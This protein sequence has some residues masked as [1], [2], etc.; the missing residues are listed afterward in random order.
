MN[1]LTP[2]Q[3]EKYRQDGYQSPNFAVSPAEALSLRRKLEAHEQLHGPLRDV[4]PHLLTTWLDSLVRTR[5]LLDVVEDLIGPDILCWGSSFFIKEAHSP[6]F[7][8]W[9]QDANYI[10]LQ[11]N[12]MVTAW[13][14]LTPSNETNGAMRV[15]PRTHRQAFT[16]RETHGAD[17]LLSRGQEI[18]VEVDESQAVMMRLQAGEFSLH[19]TL[20]VHGSDPNPSADRRIGFVAR[21]IPPHVRQ[22]ANVRDSALLVRGQDPYGNFELERSPTGDYTPEVR[23]YHREL[24][25][26]SRHVVFADNA[27][28]AAQSASGRWATT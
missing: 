26:R 13:I 22:T 12:E 8:T 24:A 5:L 20:L 15:I 2:D 4:K 28:I 11:P 9:H 21:Y 27:D 14:A 16:H 17:N 25:D 6:H 10:G 23:A 19:N 3:V 1:I 18:E 7:V